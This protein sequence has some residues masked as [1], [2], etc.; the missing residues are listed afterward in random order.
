LCLWNLLKSVFRSAENLILQ[1]QDYDTS[2]I[3]SVEVTRG[4]FFLS[5]RT[6]GSW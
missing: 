4:L 1:V 6:A 2:G 3:R 5:I